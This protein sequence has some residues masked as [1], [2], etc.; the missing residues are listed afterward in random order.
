VLS[1][2]NA[3]NVYSYIIFAKTLSKHERLNVFGLL[4]RFCLFLWGL[5]LDVGCTVHTVVYT[6]AAVAVAAGRRK[7]TIIAIIQIH[8]LEW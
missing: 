1:K 7:V 2:A 6:F 4:V 5:L 3:T 8:L